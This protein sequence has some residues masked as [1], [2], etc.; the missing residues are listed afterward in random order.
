MRCHPLAVLALAVTVSACSAGG[1]HTTPTSQ[2]ST[3]MTPTPVSPTGVADTARR[4]VATVA[5]AGQEDAAFADLAPRSQAA[6]GGRDGYGARVTAV[7]QIW[8]AWA[9]AAGVAFD[10]VPVRADVGQ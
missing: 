4:W 9:T 8:G 3:T 1:I 7:R 6:V 10:A 5:T 2:P